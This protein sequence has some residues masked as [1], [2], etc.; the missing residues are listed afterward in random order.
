MIA[1]EKEMDE[2]ALREIFGQH[3]RHVLGLAVATLLFAAGCWLAIYIGVFWLCLL[4]LTAMKGAEAAVP[5]SFGWAF[6]G[7][8]AVICV[9]VGIARWREPDERPRDDKQFWEIA[10]DL[11]LAVPR[12]TVAI[13]ETLHALIFLRPAQIQVAAG[14]MNRLHV[15]GSLPVHALPLELPD[16]AGRDRILVALQLVELIRF[17]RRGNELVVALSG[18]GSVPRRSVRVRIANPKRKPD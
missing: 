3:N 4:A 9:W 6:A 18:P 12:S 11:L 15:T 2:A 8:A 5:A 17:Q 10:A 13:W 1:S 7:G 14:L 16:S